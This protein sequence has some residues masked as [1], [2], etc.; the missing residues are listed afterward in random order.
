DELK[1][2]DLGC[3][4]GR[5]Y[6]F[7]K[8]NLNKEF[9]YTGVDNEQAILDIAANHLPKSAKL[10]NIDL[11]LS[12]WIKKLGKGSEYTLIVAFG[13]FHHI[14]SYKRREEL[15]REISNLLANK[16]VLAITYW[17]FEQNFEFLSKHKTSRSEPILDGYNFEPGDYTLT[18]SEKNIKRFCHSFSDEEIIQMYK[19]AEMNILEEYKSDGFE[20][21]MNKYVISQ[22]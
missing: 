12:D 4:N 19:E 18:F 15:L 14:K 1:V 6:N 17:Q 8:D 11:Q 16:G 2:L 10:I 21:K 22:K 7:L 5:F 3:G 9:E 20:N 13:L